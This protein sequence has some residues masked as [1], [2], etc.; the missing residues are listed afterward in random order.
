VTLYGR[1]GVTPEVVLMGIMAGCVFYAPPRPDPYNEALRDALGQLQQGQVLFNAPSEMTP[2]RE[3]C[4]A[5]RIS[6]SLTEDITAGLKRYGATGRDRLLGD[7]FMIR[8]SPFMTVNVSGSA[9]S[10]APL[11]PA[12]QFLEDGQFTEWP[13]NV[14]PLYSGKHPLI[15][16]IG[17]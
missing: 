10:I 5:V 6:R 7:A 14:T 15:L 1:I 2:G 3:E 8:V 12:D 11:T 16:T 9:F 17:I 13:Y 4:V